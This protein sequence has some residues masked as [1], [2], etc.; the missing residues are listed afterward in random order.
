MAMVAG[1]VALA[2]VEAL[3]FAGAVAVRDGAFCESMGTS[4]PLETWVKRGY[5][6]L[7]SVLGGPAGL[8]GGERAV[9][10]A[11]AG[12]GVATFPWSFPLV[13]FARDAP[14]GEP[15]DEPLDGSLDEQAGFG[16]IGSSY[17]R[18]S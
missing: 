2:M 13:P 15:L 11:V 4:Q 16:S 17:Q 14:L 10:R 18:G 9:A 3:A 12:E 5:E 1:A 6:L 8:A 7:G